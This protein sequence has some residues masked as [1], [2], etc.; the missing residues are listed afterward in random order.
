[1]STGLQTRK[2][3]SFKIFDQIAGTYDKLNKILSCGIDIYWRKQLVKRIPKKMDLKALDLAT[4]TADIPI[5]LSKE[6]NV[7][8]V[9]G[10]DMSQGMISMGRQKI[11]EKGLENKVTLQI[12]DACNL[13]LEDDLFDLST[14]TF[15]IRNFPS[16]QSSLEEVYRVLA[17]NGKLMI[18]EFGIPK[19]FFVRWVYLFYFRYLLPFVGNILS[20][21][22]D[23]Y[24]YLNKTVEDFPFGQEFTQ[25]MKKAKFK[26]VRATSLTFGICYL[27]EGEKVE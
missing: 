10:L 9:L 12:G 19:F 7:K 1:M 26:N 11:R 24:S 15:G 18:L 4:G 6:K 17:P 22:K 16:A 21:H 23:A 13:E 2:K 5:V 25:M 20:G 3:E 27:Y 14:I 8:S